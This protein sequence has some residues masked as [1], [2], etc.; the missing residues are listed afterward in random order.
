MPR[1]KSVKLTD[2]ERVEELINRAKRLLPKKELTYKADWL[3]SGGIGSDHWIVVDNYE[4]GTTLTVRFD[5]YLP[6]GSLL[7]DPKNIRLL[8]PIQKVAFH[9]RM[10]NLQ[11]FHG[12]HK[13][14]LRVIDTSVNLARYLVLNRPT[15]EPETYGFTLLTDNHMNGYFSEFAK[16]GINN[17]LKLE[18]RLLEFLHSK[19]NT[20][21]SLENILENRSPLDENF[22]VQSSRWLIN[23]N[24]Y[25]Y[26]KRLKAF[27]ISRKYLESLLGCS[28]QLFDR[29]PSVANL[30]NQFDLRYS[31]NPED[32][33]LLNPE[34]RR[35]TKNTPSIVRRTMYTHRKELR[36]FASAHNHLPEEIPFLSG[37]TFK[38][39][40]NE[41]LAP[42]GHTQ[43]LPMEIGLGGLNN[44][45][46]MITVYGEQI[47]EAVSFFAKQYTESMATL[48]PSTCYQRINT[49]ITKHRHTWVADPKFGRPSLFERYNITSFSSSSRTLNI[50]EGITLKTIHQAFYGACALL[51]GMCKP[52]REGELH[53][54]Q[55]N[56]LAF[57]FE[58]GGALLIQDLEKSG[59]M[60][61]RQ[62][63]KRPVPSLVARAIQLLQ[64]MS[65]K[66]RAIYGDTDGPMIDR[67]FYIPHRYLSASRGKVLGESL[68]SAIDTFCLLLDLP[69]DLNGEKWKIRVHEM[70][71]FFLLVMYKHHSNDLRRILGYAAGHISEDQIDEYTTFSD[72][73]PESVKYESECISDL[74]VSLEQ[75]RV[76]LDGHN[77]LQALYSHVCNHFDVTKLQSLGHEN[78]IRF[79]NLLQR[80]G[81][82]KSTVYT[83]ETKGPDGTL[84]TMEF[85]IKF[86]GLQDDQFD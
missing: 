41:D 51:I 73:D 47:V 86:E 15:F 59:V 2:E 76:N 52:V 24:A 29:Y 71:K 12:W 18:V 27:V 11:Y 14:W 8:A 22:L 66:L 45:A 74:L 81:T 32:A 84:T 68:N 62:V 82:Y 39:K 83:V 23:Q 78:F 1:K 37:E 85:A 17:T 4:D 34:D 56:C 57:E 48:H 6:D 26:S 65:S 3:R 80:D 46:E 9:L 40:H 69:R 42:D 54:I 43:L 19:I 20:S 53:K 63:I 31:S 7:S 61:E 36:I 67:L 64:V 38:E 30:L 10:G 13:Q 55:L 77:G 21:V 16:G 5:D 58:G 72:D 49:N 44:A 79:L 75:G 50:K 33:E 60:D 35:L 70:R 25:I 28:S